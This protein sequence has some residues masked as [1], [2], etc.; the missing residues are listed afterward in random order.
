MS[1]WARGFTAPTPRNN[2]KS[3][4]AA[5]TELSVRLGGHC[6]LWDRTGQKSAACLAEMI[7]TKGAGL[8]GVVDAPYRDLDRRRCATKKPVCPRPAL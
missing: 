5:R 8:G 3:R 2:W 1:A 6:S 4:A 7:D